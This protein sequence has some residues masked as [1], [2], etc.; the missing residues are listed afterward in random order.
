MKF[1]AYYEVCCFWL[2]KVQLFVQLILE[3]KNVWFLHLGGIGTTRWFYKA[4]F[5]SIN[6][7]WLYHY[8]Y[9]VIVMK[10]LENKNRDLMIILYYNNK[11]HSSLALYVSQAKYPIHKKWPILYIWINLKIIHIEMAML[12]Y[13]TVGEIVTKLWK[14]TRYLFFI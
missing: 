5:G 3:S 8:E 9:V 2:V 12:I 7:Y 14:M 1:C 6:N 4:Y 11:L 10:F 13:I